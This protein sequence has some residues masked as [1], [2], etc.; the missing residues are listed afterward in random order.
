MEEERKCFTNSQLGRVF[1]A[2]IVFPM[3]TT[4]FPQLPFIQPTLRVWWKRGGGRG[5]ITNRPPRTKPRQ[6]NPWLRFLHFYLYSGSL[7]YHVISCTDS[8]YITSQFIQIARFMVLDY[9]IL[10]WDSAFLHNLI[11]SAFKIPWRYFCALLLFATI[12]TFPSNNH[13]WQEV[14]LS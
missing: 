11:Q 6:M 12:L 2:L 4:P 7:V 1:L 9:A 3:K 13:G 10:I 5:G 14:L 8:N